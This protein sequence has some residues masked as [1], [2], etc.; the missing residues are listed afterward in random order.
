VTLARDLSDRTIA[1]L[2]DRHGLRELRGDA[3]GPYLP[4]PGQ[5]PGAEGVCRVWEG[6][7]VER[8]VYVGLGFPPAD[9][10]SHMVFAFT[11]ADSLVPHFTLDSVQAGGM[12]AFHLDLIPR[13]DLGSQLR[14]LD[15]V[16]GPLTEPYMAGRA[17]A[18]LSEAELSPRQLA[19]MSPWMLAYRANDDAFTAIEEFVNTY[20]DHWSELLD[21][22]VPA[23]VVE[24]MDGPQIAERDGR[25]RAALFNPDVD[26]VW[27]KIEPLIGGEAGEHIRD[28]LRGAELR[29]GSV[30]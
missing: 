6:D 19:L 10:D 18:G 22:G 21:A 9:L 30:L 3:G 23:A 12:R 26:P 7:I 25:N 11:P 29:T 13:V 20:M 8:V 28:L 27:G 14:Y 2:V 16:F 4:L 5:A 24:G 1:R 15:H 17:I